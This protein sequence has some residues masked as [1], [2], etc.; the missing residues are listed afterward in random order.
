MDYTKRYYGKTDGNLLEH[1]VLSFDSECYEKDVDLGVIKR[2]LYILLRFFHEFQPVWG[3]HLVKSHYHIH[4]VINT[5]NAVTGKK[6]RKSQHEFMQ[7]LRQLADELRDYHIALLPISYYDDKGRF[8]YG[9]VPSTFLYQNKDPFIY[10]M[11][12]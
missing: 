1:Y 4:I 8:R 9:K 12:E 2:C 5:V 10:G 6:Y 3:I 11:Y 7:L